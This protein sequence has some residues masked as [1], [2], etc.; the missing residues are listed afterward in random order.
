MADDDD[1]LDRFYMNQIVL[2]INKIVENL[3]QGAIP[4]RGDTLVKKGFQVL[5]L[6][7][8]ENQN[9]DAYP[10]L[11]VIC[12]PGDDDERVHRMERDLKVW[13]PA[14]QQVADAVRQG[15]KVLVTCMAGLNRSG[16]VI[17]LALRELT[18]WSG[19]AIVKHM[20]A[21]RPYALC[22]STFEKYIKD[23]FPDPKTS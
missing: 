1:T 12:A 16:M 4:P 18:G 22:N 13:I 14:A 20:K 21:Q 2:D 19:P 10:G 8:S 23:S 6:C 5:V 9:A 15:K 7:A 17:A 3:W 11:Q